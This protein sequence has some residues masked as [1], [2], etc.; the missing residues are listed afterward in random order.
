MRTTLQN[1]TI[2]KNIEIFKI[3]LKK[4]TQLHENASGV[5]KAAQSVLVFIHRANGEIRFFDHY[6]ETLIPSEWTC[7]R[8]HFSPSTL[9]QESFSIDVSNVNEKHFSWE[10]LQPEAF[11]NL[12]ETIKTI[13]FISRFLPKLKSFLSI[14]KEFSL[15]NLDVLLSR[16]PKQDVV[17]EAWHNLNRKECEQLLLSHPP[18]VFLFRKDEFASILEEE[19]SSA[20]KQKM[21]CITLSY[22]SS[23]KKISDLTLV[24]TKD[25]WSLYND[26][27]G[28]EE[29]RYPTVYSLLDSMRGV[30]NT[31]LM[32]LQS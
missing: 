28:L 29:A 6:A 31:P 22:V 26:S 12:K 7:I 4:M 9:S 3:I 16:F 5:D 19:L 32:T 17:H 15:T 10:D 2:R 11:F 23:L 25:G 8:F 30:C 21:T 18:G 27:P 13:Q 14:L 1:E 24:K 20:H